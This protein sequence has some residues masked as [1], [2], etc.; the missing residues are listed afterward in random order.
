MNTKTI[1]SLLLSRDER[2][3]QIAEALVH[4]IDDK[5]EFGWILECIYCFTAYNLYPLVSE[6][7]SSKKYRN[8]IAWFCFHSSQEL[9]FRYDQIHRQ[10]DKNI[11]IKEL[12]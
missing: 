5:F 12:E 1:L 4:T 9:E 3:V 10:E 7:Y 11:V 8:T 2:D 6:K